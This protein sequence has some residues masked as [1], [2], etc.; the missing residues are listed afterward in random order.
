[1]AHADAAF[2]L[3]VDEKKTN[4][5]ERIWMHASTKSATKSFS[6]KEAR[7]WV[8]TP[9]EEVNPAL[10]LLVAQGYIRQAQAKPNKTGRP[11]GPRYIVNEAA[12]PQKGGA[13]KP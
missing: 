12:L 4:L 10:H 13:K 2:S 3:M 8:K 11:A 5:S 7:D 9:I 1:M 6:A